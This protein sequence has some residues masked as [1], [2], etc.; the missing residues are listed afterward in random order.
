MKYIVA[1]AFLWL[2]APVHAGSMMLLGTGTISVGG[3]AVD[4][5]C[6]QGVTYLARTAGGNEG[7]NVAN[8]QLLICGLV[9]DGV[10]TGNMST[11][12]CGAPLDALYIFAQQTAADSVL[13]LC[14]TS[15]TA[16]GGVNTFTAL[17]GWN[18]FKTTGGSIN[19][20]FNSTTAPS[21]N[22][23]QNSASYG[24][25]SVG[26]VLSENANQVVSKNSGTGQSNMFAAFTDGLFY[27][28]VNNS[29]VFG[30]S[31]PATKGLYVGERP[32]STTVT[33][34]VNGVAQASSAQASEAPAN[35]NYFFG[36]GSSQTIAEGHIG[37][38]LG[39]A[40]N[41]ALYNRLRIYMTAVG[42]P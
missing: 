25:W 11:T 34:Y 1:F 33:P 18:G 22:Y 23:N 8:I 41:L 15:F 39:A 30:V 14:K 4:P 16:Q 37:G 3:P 21:P 7:G 26:P 35:S 19:S 9:L 24:F 38:A 32:S 31:N 17:V 27:I 42:V 5:N 20:T 13:N 6:A 28:R 40:L 29:T 36:V 12:G 2:V 10:I